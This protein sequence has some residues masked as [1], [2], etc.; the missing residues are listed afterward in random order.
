MSRKK[1][2]FGAH[3]VVVAALVA[4]LA[5][6]C[7]AQFGAPM[8]TLVQ[9]GRRPVH[10][11]GSGPVPDHRSLHAA[12]PGRPEPGARD[13]ERVLWQWPLLFQG[14]TLVLTPDNGRGNP[15]SAIQSL[16][17]ADIKQG[18]K[19]TLTTG[20]VVG[21]GDYALETGSWVA[22]SPEG[23]HLD[24]GTYMTLYKKEGAGW[25]I[26]RDTWNSSMAKP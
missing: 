25:K 9:G 3:A 11:H 10:C 15:T 17:T 23:K 14:N 22:T 21:F 8:G 5:A 18:A 16:F 13:H 4:T 20:D 7:V 2:C 26:Y 6:P 1:S 19:N 24:H 12:Q